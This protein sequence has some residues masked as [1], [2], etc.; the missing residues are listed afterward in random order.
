MSN[1]RVFHF[2]CISV[3]SDVCL[4][5]FIDLSCVKYNGIFQIIKNVRKLIAWR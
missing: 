5:R 1:S 3:Q 2:T 4:N